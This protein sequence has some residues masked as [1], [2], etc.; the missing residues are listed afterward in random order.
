MTREQFI[1]C[2]PL[3]LGAYAS[4]T[5]ILY[6]G[7]VNRFV[8]TRRQFNVV[9]FIWQMFTVIP[10]F[11]VMQVCA[12]TLHLF[13]VQSMSTEEIVHLLTIVVLGY[14]M[15]LN[16]AFGFV[17]IQFPEAWNR[18]DAFERE[19]KKAAR[20]AAKQQGAWSVFG[21]RD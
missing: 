14:I 16:S 19:A 1:R 5:T 20:A 8:S 18:Y 7:C 4:V 9:R 10:A 2:A 15:P 6:L 13:E 17:A 21:R 3:L 11:G 12:R